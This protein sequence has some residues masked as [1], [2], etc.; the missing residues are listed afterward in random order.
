MLYDP[1]DYGEIES[2]PSLSASYGII[3]SNETLTLGND[4]RS[5]MSGDDPD[6]TIVLLRTDGG[7]SAYSIPAATATSERS[8]PIA[9]SPRMTTTPAL[10]LTFSSPT[11]PVMST[12]L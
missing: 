3:L 11:V 1:A 6:T 4:L 2:T 8:L 5:A 12:V 9:T 10:A 7:D